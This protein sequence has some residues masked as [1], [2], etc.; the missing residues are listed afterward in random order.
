MVEID[1][2]IQYKNCLKAID[3]G[4]QVILT[5]HSEQNLGELKTVQVGI[6]L[7]ITHIL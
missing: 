3:N 7:H 6:S 1:F 4:Y 5:A 2:V